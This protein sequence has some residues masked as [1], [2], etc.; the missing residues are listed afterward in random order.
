MFDLDTWQELADTIRANK[1]RTILTGSSVA[2]G[3]FMLIVL[4]GS[5][6]GLQN[7]A[8]YQF[9]DDAVNS[10]WVRSGETSLPHRGLPPGRRVQFRNA[11]HDEVKT[12]VDGVDHITSRYYFGNPIVAHGAKSSTFDVRSVHPDHR[13]L[14]NTLVVSG[15]FLNDLDI[16]EHRKVAALGKKVVA[17]LFAEGEDP[18][19]QLVEINGIAFK[20]VGVFD[21]EGGESEQEK[22]YIPISTA[23][24]AFDGQDRVGMFMFTT[25]D[26]TLAASQAMA[27]EVRDL[28]ATR[29]RFAPEDARAVSIN[30]NNEMFQRIQSLMAGIRAF[31]WVLGVGTILAGVVGVSNIMMIVVRERTREFGIRKALGATPASILVLVLQEAV[32]ITAASGY[33][34]LVLGVVLLEVISARVPGAEF[35]RDPHVD[36]GTALKATA[37]LVV[38][39]TLAGA[40]PARRAAL[41]PPIEALREE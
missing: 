7:G 19:S 38:A 1:L 36:L 24:R 30:N 16:A 31:I 5:G 32:V 13:V 35:F 39:G 14:E 15:R 4:L 25:G 10:I 22:I 41:L 26:Q 23:Q 37:L 6:Q 11:D 34:G 40:V 8:A 18:V 33:V 2:W 28:L 12:R 27:T 3:I 29:H 17:A 20:V 21:D 9:R